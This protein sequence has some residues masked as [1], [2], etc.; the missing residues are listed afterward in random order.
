MPRSRAMRQTSRSGWMTPV[1][2]LAAI[3]EIIAAPGSSASN[4]IQIQTPSRVHRRVFHRP[5]QIL[6]AAE[7]RGV[8][9]RRDHRGS[10]PD[11]PVERMH[12][13]VHALGAAAGEDDFIGLRA[14]PCGEFGARV[15]DGL[16]RPPRPGVGAGGVGM[17]V[18]QPR[19]HRLK[20]FR[21]QRRARVGVQMNH[22]RSIRRCG[23][24]SISK[25]SHPDP[26]PSTLG[27]LMIQSEN[28]MAP[29]A[30]KTSTIIVAAAT[31]IVNLAGC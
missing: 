31:I 16:A 25:F 13:G 7:H 3:T 8:L 24:I 29:A 14:D 27:D 21:Q 30:Q 23:A 6:R 1:S 20:H 22:V 15:L 17:S 11:Q 19:Q 9:D 18:A 4:L 28:D 5:R 10:R 26:V 12:G 2:L